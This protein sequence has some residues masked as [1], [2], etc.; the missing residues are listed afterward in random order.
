MC[1]SERSRNDLRLPFGLREGR[2]WTPLEVENGEAC[3]CVCPT[4]KA[5][6]T[7]KHGH[8]KRR[9]H[10]SHL[11]NNGCAG[12]LESDIHLLAKQLIMD[13]FKVLLPAWNGLADFPNPPVGRTRSGRLVQGE[14]VAWR[15][16][17]V[18]LQD[19]RLEPNFGQFRPDIIARDEQGELL[20]EIKVSH[21]VDDTKA[22]LVRQR[23]LRMVEIDLSN[24]AMATP[25]NTEKF[26]NQV[27][28]LE[29]NRTW[30]SNP[31]AENAWR[32]ARDRVIALAAEEPDEN[33]ILGGNTYQIS[34]K[35]ILGS[36]A[37]PTFRP[38]ELKP[39]SPTESKDPLQYPRIGTSTWQPGLGHG[40]ILSRA[41][42]ARAI[43]YVEFE[44][45]I[46]MILFREDEPKDWF[47]EG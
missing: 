46:R 8:G 20:I 13:N 9:P 19:I 27:L 6:V 26:K 36:P 32:L 22:E 28:F 44:C 1:Q 23:G 11:A 12:N 41:T 37:S 47:W 17:M 25:F 18:D 4:C 10:F 40:V 38:G 15:A 14:K 5:P 2:I 34:K 35:R 39:L 16:K 29:T 30:I 42:R 31:E 7:A 43:Y 45:G 24:I 21:A 33:G 3:G